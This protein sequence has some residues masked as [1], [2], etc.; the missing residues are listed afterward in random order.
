MKGGC[1]SQPQEMRLDS[2]EIR[3][4]VMKYMNKERHELKVW[5]VLSSGVVRYF[6]MGEIQKRNDLWGVSEEEARTVGRG[7]CPL[8]IWKTQEPI[9][10][11]TQVLIEQ[12]LQATG[13]AW[14]DT[15]MYQGGMREIDLA[16]SW[17]RW[18]VD[19]GARSCAIM[20]VGLR[21]PGF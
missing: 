19:R 2:G 9:S 7:T 10:C 1:C 16:S 21:M 14:R 12:L 3:Q 4:Q 18:S 15:T 6:A 13:Q 8:H 17:G 20:L 11:I 5:L